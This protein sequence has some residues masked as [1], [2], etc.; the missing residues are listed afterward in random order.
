[1]NKALKWILIIGGV[2]VALIV[3]AIV[4]IPFVVDVNKYKP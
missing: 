2:F 1:M 4:I 3:A